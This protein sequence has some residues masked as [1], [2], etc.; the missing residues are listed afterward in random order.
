[1]GIELDFLPRAGFFENGGPLKKRTFEIALYTWL[2]QLNPDRVDYLHSKNVPS[3]RNNYVG[4]NFMD[5]SNPRVDELLVKGGATIDE[6]ER[7]PIYLE[8]QKIITDDLPFL[9]LYQSVS[10]IV[11]RAKLQNFKPTATSTPETWNV[12]QWAMS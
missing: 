3:D 9:P 7:R 5:Y 11:A 6:K 4:N 1:V 8:L 2:S 10:P 12:Y